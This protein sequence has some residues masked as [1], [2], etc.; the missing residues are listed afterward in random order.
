MSLFSIGNNGGGVNRGKGNNW[1]RG[2]RRPQFSIHFD[3][4]PHELNY[5]FQVGFFN[6]VGQ[7]ILQPIP[8]RPPFQPHQNFSSIHVPPHVSMQ[9]EPPASDGWQEIFHQPVAH[10]HAWPTVSLPLPPP[11]PPINPNAQADRIV[12]PIQSSHACKR[13]KISIM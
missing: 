12:S 2:H 9:L 8:E 11:P 13:N 10:H 7:G 6:L 4:D 5:L 1:Q 3:D